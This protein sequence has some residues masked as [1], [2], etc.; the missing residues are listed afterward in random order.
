MKIRESGAVP[1]A[2]RTEGAIKVEF[3]V[4]AIQIDPGIVGN[5]LLEMTTIQ[6]PDWT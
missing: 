6:G 1:L 5:D 2:W 3:D 4:R